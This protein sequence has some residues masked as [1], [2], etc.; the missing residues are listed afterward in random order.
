MEATCLQNMSLCKIYS[1]IVV[2]LL[3]LCLS[4][5]MIYDRDFSREGNLE[6][7]LPPLT[8]PSQ[9]TA[10]SPL[11]S[12]FNLRKNLVIP[13]AHVLYCSQCCTG[14]AVLHYLVQ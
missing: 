13:F 11:Y 7:V 10:V 8:Q 2:I 9:L 4:L 14:C 5:F 6:M 1:I 3:Y 12:Y